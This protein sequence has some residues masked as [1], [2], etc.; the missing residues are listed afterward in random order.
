MRIL[1]K[2]VLTALLVV[3]LAL[4]AVFLILWL[5]RK[6][7]IQARDKKF[8]SVEIKDGVAWIFAD[9]VALLER[10]GFNRGN[11]SVR[12]LVESFEAKYGEELATQFV[13]MID[14]NDRALF[15]TQVMEES[16]REVALTFHSWTIGKLNSEVKWYTR[17]WFKWA[18]CLY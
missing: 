8:R 18:L 14:L 11:G 6:L 5:R 2:T 4:L 17:L 9:T 10:L 15:S 1:V 13:Q 12:T 16:E 7:L 3:L